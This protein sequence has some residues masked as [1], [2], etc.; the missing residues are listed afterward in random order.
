[1]IIANVLYIN[2][3]LMCLLRLT[4]LHRLKVLQRLRA[5]RF[6]VNIHPYFY[7]CALLLPSLKERNLPTLLEFSTFISNR[8]PVIKNDV[9][10]RGVCVLTIIF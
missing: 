10:A 6:A 4:S 3:R 7:F 8:S 9:R 1:M 5:A 2:F